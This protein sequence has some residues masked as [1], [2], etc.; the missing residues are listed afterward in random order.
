MFHAYGAAGDT[1]E[2]LDGPLEGAFDHLWSA[3]LHQDPRMPNGTGGGP[4]IPFARKGH[5][6]MPRAIK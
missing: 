4:P 1:A 6:H 3:I 2:I 5:W